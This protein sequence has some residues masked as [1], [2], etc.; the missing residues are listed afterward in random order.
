[1]ILI[2]NDKGSLNSLFLLKVLVIVLAFFTLIFGGSNC[3]ANEQPSEE[4][5]LPEPPRYRVF[6][7]KHISA[8]QAEKLKLP[9]RIKLVEDL[10]CYHNRISPLSQ[11]KFSKEDFATIIEQAKQLIEQVKSGLNEKE[12]EA[13]EKAKQL[14]EQVRARIKKGRE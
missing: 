2:K 4:K 7:L 5:P 8:E 14:I 9:F 12:R 13:L 1:M 3:I 11:R 6:N 10:R